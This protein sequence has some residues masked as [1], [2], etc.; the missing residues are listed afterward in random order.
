MNEAAI[1]LRPAVPADAALIF[2]LI[3]SLPPIREDRRDRSQ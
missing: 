1:N 2:T 3:A